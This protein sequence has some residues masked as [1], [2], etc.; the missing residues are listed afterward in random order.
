MQEKLEANIEIK[1]KTDHLLGKYNKSKF[2]KHLIRLL[3]MN[4]SN[5]WSRE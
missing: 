4:S 1:D 5:Y 2:P 3:S